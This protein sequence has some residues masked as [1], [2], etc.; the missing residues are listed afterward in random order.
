MQQ[1]KTW[2]FFSS[3]FNLFRVRVLRFSI[4]NSS[5]LLSLSFFVSMSVSVVLLAFFRRV[6]SACFFLK[7]WLGSLKCMD[8]RIAFWLL[9]SMSFLFL[10]SGVLKN[11][12]VFRIYCILWIVHSIKQITNLFL[13]FSLWKIL[14]VFLV[15]QLFKVSV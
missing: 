15:W 12:F 14:N 13:Q 2:T 7:L 3:W 6:N 10:F 9:L 5:L 8:P 1:I 4:D 11:V